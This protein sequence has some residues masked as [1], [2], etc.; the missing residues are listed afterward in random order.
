VLIDPIAAD[1]FE[2]LLLG[3]VRHRGEVEGVELLH[4][5]EGDERMRE[6]SGSCKETIWPTLEF[7]EARQCSAISL[8]I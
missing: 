6:P 2:D 4:H 8:V 1:Q 3:Q 5:W 7:E